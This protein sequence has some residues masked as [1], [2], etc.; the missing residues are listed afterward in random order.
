MRRKRE[1][2]LGIRGWVEEKWPARE[3]RGQPER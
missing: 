1:K 2:N 3:G